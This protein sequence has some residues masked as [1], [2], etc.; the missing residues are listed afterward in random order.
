M[1]PRGAVGAKRMI[2]TRQL[3]YLWIKDV[4]VDGIDSIDGN[5]ELKER[6]FEMRTILMHAKAA[7]SRCNY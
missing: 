1:I 6:P 5:C 2:N 7:R 3:S 4:A